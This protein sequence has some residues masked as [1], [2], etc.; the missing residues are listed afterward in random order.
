MVNGDAV[1]RIGAEEERLG[2]TRSVPRRGHIAPQRLDALL[3]K[4][5]ARFVQLGVE[6]DD[7]RLVETGR[8]G[9]A[10]EVVNARVGKGSARLRRQSIGDEVARRAAGRVTRMNPLS[11][12][13][14]GRKLGRGAGFRNRFRVR[15]DQLFVEIEAGVHFGGRAANDDVTGQSAVVD[16][17]ERRMRGPVSGHGRYEERITGVASSAHLNLA[18]DNGH[19]CRQW[20]HGQSRYRH[21]ARNRSSGGDL[22]VGQSARVWRRAAGRVQQCS[23]FKNV[24]NPP[25]SPHPLREMR[26]EVT[27][28]D[29]VANGLIAIAAAVVRHLQRE[30]APRPEGLAVEVG[31]VVAIGRGQPLMGVLMV[32]VM[33]FRAGTNEPEFDVVAE[34]AV[35][36]VGWIVGVERLGGFWP[37]RWSTG[38]SQTDVVGTGSVRRH[39]HDHCRIADR[40]RREEELFVFTFRA[41]MHGTDTQ[42][43]CKNLGACA[44]RAVIDGEAVAHAVERVTQNGIFELGECLHGP[45]L[46]VID[47]GELTERLIAIG[48]GRVRPECPCREA[49]TTRSCDD[50]REV[51]VN[52]RVPL[53]QPQNRQT[54]EAMPGRIDGLIIDDWMTTAAGAGRGQ[55]KILVGHLAAIPLGAGRL[56]V[57][58]SEQACVE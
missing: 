57:H 47:D 13:R 56:H 12:E 40:P 30:C 3:R 41:G 23:A 27:V 19:R 37:R 45:D 7:C 33:L 16:G 55:R 51:G 15:G 17:V 10:P 42:A 44:R 24:V 25:Q 43:V 39:I 31:R 34:I 48:R 8:A 58:R 11:M 29:R 9:G 32:N 5:P 53:A 54:G 6:L 49:A 52:D 38:K 2:R 22:A 26:V 20:C 46:I 4:M 21:D 35:V 18:A 50:C 28:K 36:D 1:L 14:D